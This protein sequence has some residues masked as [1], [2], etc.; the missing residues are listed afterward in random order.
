ML[1]ASAIDFELK[2]YTPPDGD[3]VNFELVQ[4]VAHSKLLSFYASGKV[5]KPEWDNP[6]G[7]FGIYQMRMTKKGKVPIRMKF[8]TPTN[9]QTVPQQANRSKFADAMTAWVAL[10]PTAKAEYIKRAKR[11]N[12]F[13]HG[14]F[15]REYFS[16]H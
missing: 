15:I 8:Y 16:T 12:M 9:P 3:A 5:G 7:H 14:L 13:G 6:E 4:D 10:T 2:I 1:T 11:R